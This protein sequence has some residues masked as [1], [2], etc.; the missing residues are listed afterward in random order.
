MTA[1]DAGRLSQ[2]GASGTVPILY[3][4]KV[5]YFS[6]PHSCIHKLLW[7]TSTDEELEEHRREVRQLAHQVDEAA[8]H[9]EVRQLA[10]QTDEAA[11][12]HEEFPED[13]EKWVAFA[14]NPLTPNTRV[15]LTAVAIDVALDFFSIFQYIITDNFIFAALLVAI[16]VS[17]LLTDYHEDVAGRLPEDEKKTV[18]RGVPT[19]SIIKLLD[20]E[21]GYEAFLSIAVTAYALPYA[22]QDVASSEKTR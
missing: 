22:N 4:P 11:E 14:W 7:R 13:I 5:P 17:S 9:R 12:G 18:K 10:A 2:A 8:H 20:K 19:D 21:A 15:K 1:R 16:L 3:S 6:P